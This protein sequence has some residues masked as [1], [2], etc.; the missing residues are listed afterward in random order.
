MEVVLG[1]IKTGFMGMSEFKELVAWD[2]I[3]K[4]KV[5]KNHK[6]PSETRVHHTR[7]LNTGRKDALSAAQSPIG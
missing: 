6:H 5:G 3:R 1:L 2:Y 7:V 4:R